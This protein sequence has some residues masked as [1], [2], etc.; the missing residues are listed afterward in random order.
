M[1]RIKII[2]NGCGGVSRLGTSSTSDK[3]SPGAVKVTV[4]PASTQLRVNAK[5]Q[6]SAA[7]SNNSNKTVSWSVNGIAGGNATI[8]KVDSTGLYQA[9]VALPSP[10]FI[11]VEATSAA[12]STV[13]ASASVTVEN[14]V[15][16]VA[17]VSPASIPMGRLRSRWGPSPCPVSVRRRRISFGKAGWEPAWPSGIRRRKSGRRFCCHSRHPRKRPS[18]GNSSASRSMSFRPAGSL[19]APP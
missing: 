1:K 11:S 4:T 13:S 15:P 2:L 14:P 16:T 17:S 3:P 8:G 18:I 19:F 7:V 5:K 12:D 10:N 9:P 6:F